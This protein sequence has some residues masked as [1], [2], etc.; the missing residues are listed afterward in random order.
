MSDPQ[1]PYDNLPSWND[2]YADLADLSGNTPL[3]PMEPPRTPQAQPPGSPLL[4]GLVV[5]LLLIALSVAVFQV[6][7]PDDDGTAAALSTTTTL[8][9]TSSSTTLKG[10]DTSTTDGLTTSTAPPL[11]TPT[12]GTPYAAVGDPIPVTDLK[13]KGDGIKVTTDGV[14]DITFGSDADTAIGELVSSL[15]TPTQDT[16][17][18]TSTGQF[19]V[20]VGDAER[21][22]YFGPLATIVT[23]SNGKEVFSGYRSDIQFGALTNPAAS[24]ETLSGLKIGDK[25]ADLKEIYAGEKVEF[26]TDTKLGQIYKVIGGST[27]NLLLWGPIEGTADDDSVIGIYAPD[28]CNEN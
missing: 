13:L 12:P 17:W 20:C 1:D 5:G 22:V 2:P 14:D 23:K 24:L 9:G 28:V 10:T 3:P 21:I 15:G 18:Q 8:D 11:S 27:G 19:G 4:V 26:A 6:L 16:Q 7:G 25:V